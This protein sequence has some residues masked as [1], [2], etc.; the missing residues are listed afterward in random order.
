MMYRFALGLFAKVCLIL[1]LSV[2]VNSAGPQ[3]ARAQS[4][5]VSVASVT[6]DL[7]RET[8]ATLIDNVGAQFI[9]NG[10]TTLTRNNRSVSRAACP[11]LCVANLINTRVWT[12]LIQHLI[13]NIYIMFWKLIAVFSN[14]VASLRMSFILQKNRSTI[15]RI[16]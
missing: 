11:S 12:Q 1:T 13:A 2:L 7:N 4:A 16:A 15:L 10:S 6:D 8:E 3:S 9:F 14:L 5:N